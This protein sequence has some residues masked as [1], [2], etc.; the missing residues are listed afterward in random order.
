MSLAFGEPL[1]PA[2]EGEGE[3]EGEDLPAELPVVDKVGEALG[4]VVE[5]PHP[6]VPHEIGRN[7]GVNSIEY[8]IT[9]SDVVITSVP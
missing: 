4:D 2:G 3:A 8:Q 9:Y 5:Q 7:L 6:G 1:L